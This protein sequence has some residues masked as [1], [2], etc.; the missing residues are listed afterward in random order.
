MLEILSKCKWDTVKEIPYVFVNRKQGE[1]KLK[2]STMIQFIKQLIDD[3][4]FPGRARDEIRKIANF[5]IVGMIGIA[6]N[7]IALALLKDY[8]PLLGASFVAIELSIIGNYILND[9]WTFKENN[10]GTWLHRMISYNGVAIGGMVINMITLATLSLFGVWYILANLVG[11]AL[12]F[13]WN[14]LGNRKL[15]W[16]V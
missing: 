11:I 2:K 6:T 5:G 7:M 3:A 13:A 12:G 4:L 15:T 8:I 1:S 10:T 9:A 14:F 16:T